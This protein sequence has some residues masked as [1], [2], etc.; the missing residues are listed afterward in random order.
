MLSSI[1]E[2]R[3]LTQADIRFSKDPTPYK[4]SHDI[5]TRRLHPHW[6][7]RHLTHK[8]GIAV[9][10][11]ERAMVSYELLADFFQDLFFSSL[12]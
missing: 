12:V 11:L 2:E 9:R 1:H 6:N 3:S 4:V 7:D 10:N 5:V 8:H